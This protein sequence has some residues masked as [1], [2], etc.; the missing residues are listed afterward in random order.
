MCAGQ[1]GATAIIMAINAKPNPSSYLEWKTVP[2]LKDPIM[3]VGFFG[4]SNAGCVAGDTLAHIDE[5]LS[6]NIIATLSDEPFINFT[7]E[8]PTAEI[9]DGIIQHVAPMESELRSAVNPEADSDLILLLGKEP[10]FN[11]LTYAQVLVD[12]MLRLKVKKL[13]TIGGVQDTISHSGQPLISVLGS[14]TRVVEE[15][16][17]LESGIQAANYQGPI[18]VHTTLVMAGMEA[19]IPTVS[20]WAHVPAYLHKN[21]RQVARI[22]NILNK[23]AGMSCPVDILMKQ[24]IEL[25]RKID[26]ALGRD[27]HLKE[28]VETIE[29]RNEPPSSAGREEKIIRLND[30]L[31]REPHKDPES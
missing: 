3:I 22:V 8:R 7:L 11:W 18:S 4:W 20:L 6:T 26:E 21:P 24:S 27:P 29:G 25:D 17:E 30:F 12:A 31:R 19:G 5:V 16:G 15:M 13:I 28:F 14:S 23:C 1:V 2:D 9:R 10:H